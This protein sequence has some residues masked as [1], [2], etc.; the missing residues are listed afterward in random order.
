MVMAY[1]N[2]INNGYF[3]QYGHRKGMD[4]IHSTS[5]CGRRSLKNYVM[6]EIVIFNPFTPSRSNCYVCVYECIKVFVSLP[7]SAILYS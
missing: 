1:I 5:R 2:V 6:E 7:A 4:E 3:A